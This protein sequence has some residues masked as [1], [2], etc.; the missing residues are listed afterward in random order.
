MER[1][2][3]APLG[4]SNT[5]PGGVGFSAENLARIGV[6]LDNHGKYGEWEL[7]SE[8]T[9]Q[10]IIPTSLSTYFPNIDMKYG[11]GLQSYEPRLG[12]GSYGHG[13]G[14][15]TQL[16]VNPDK[17]LVFAMVRNDPGDRYKEHLA[18]TMSILGSWIQD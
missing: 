10:A 16:I 6:M 12:P 1:E 5:L 8:K 2:L 7:F 4:I 14:C 3:F 9:Y 13:G 17:H 18:D 15:G 11:I